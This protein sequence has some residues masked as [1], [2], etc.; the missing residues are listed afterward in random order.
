MYIIIRKLYYKILFPKYVNIDIVSFFS[1]TRRMQAFL[2]ILLNKFYEILLNKLYGKLLN[3]N[4]Y[5]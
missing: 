4:Y 2:L 5:Y 1:D 3:N